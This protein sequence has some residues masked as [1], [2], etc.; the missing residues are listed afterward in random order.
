MSDSVNWGIWLPVIGAV[1]GFCAVS[2]VGMVLYCYCRVRD[3]L[4]PS[5][6][7][8][9]AANVRDQQERNLPPNEIGTDSVSEDRESGNRTSSRVRFQEDDSSAAPPRN[10]SQIIFSG[11][12]HRTA[13]NRDK[14]LNDE[15][16]SGRT[17]REFL[18]IEDEPQSIS[19]PRSRNDSNM[20]GNIAPSDGL[21]LYDAE[22]ENRHVRSGSDD[23]GFP[24]D[25]HIV[26]HDDGSQDV[27]V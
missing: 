19:Q 15:G 21:R 22:I 18:M 8:G 6:Y 26:D 11:G 1:S 7:V 4:S 9:G 20:I 2:S 14:V 25:D 16:E 3:S 5:R 10:Q 24:R 27:F 12:Q 23:M 17:G 13:K